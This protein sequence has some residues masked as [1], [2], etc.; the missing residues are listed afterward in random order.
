MAKKFIFSF[1]CAMLFVA[2]ALPAFAQSEGDFFNA[3]QQNLPRSKDSANVPLS[4]AAETVITTSTPSADVFSSYKI[5]DAGRDDI[6]GYIAGGAAIFGAFAIA[7]ALG[8]VLTH[9]HKS[10]EDGT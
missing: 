7:L 1:V 8:F 9:R 10:P 4:G 3:L 2:L 5:Y 6:S